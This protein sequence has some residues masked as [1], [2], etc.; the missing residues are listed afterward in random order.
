MASG[1]RDRHD[2]WLGGTGS[3]GRVRAA[4]DAMCPMS[5][6]AEPRKA[7]PRQGHEHGR[8]GTCYMS[9]LP[10]PCSLQCAFKPR[11]NV[12]C[13]CYQG[14]R[15]GMQDVQTGAAACH[16]CKRRPGLAGR[17]HGGR[18]DELCRQRHITQLAARIWKRVRIILAQLTH[19]EGAR[20]G[21]AAPRRWRSGWARRSRWRRASQSRTSAW[22]PL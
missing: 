3:P 1:A 9:V 17:A 5:S 6:L 11:P 18:F 21:R 19:G 10:I 14:K 7:M 20:A 16:A 2:R 22:R 4:T 13:V 12:I 8:T 15:L